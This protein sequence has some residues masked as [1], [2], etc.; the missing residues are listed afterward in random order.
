[1][2]QMQVDAIPEITL[3]HA[4]DAAIADLLS[5]A[6]DTDFGGRSF[7]KQRH[8]LR[9]VV[10]N[11]TQIIGHMGLCYRAI[12]M[13]NQLIDIVGLAEV[14]THPDHRKK[15]IASTLMTHAVQAAKQSKADFFILFGDEAI[16]AA[17]G[18]RRRPNKMTFVVMDDAK[19]HTIKTALNNALMVM[20]LTEKAWDDQATIDWLGHLF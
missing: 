5:Q 3:S 14:A 17:S 1:M 8:H 18:F 4:D 16:Y 9:L 20:D 2:P 10:R 13:G 12:R 6:F 7:Y 15:G 19:T 11:D